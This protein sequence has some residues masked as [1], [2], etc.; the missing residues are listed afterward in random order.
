MTKKEFIDRYGK[1]AYQRRLEYQKQ[2]YHQHREERKQYREQH[3]EERKQYQKQY[4]HQ[5]REEYKQY[6]KQYRE[7]HREERK[8]YQ[9][10]YRE[11]HREQHREEKKQWCR[12]HISMFAYCIPEQIEQ[13]ENYQF[14]KK[15]N[16]DGWNIHHRLE[17]HTSD[18]EK[19]LVNLSKA[20]L[21]ALDMYYNRPANELVFLTKSE[22][23]SL[24]NRRNGLEN[25]LEK[26]YN[27]GVRRKK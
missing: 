20:E 19:R 17:T 4:N 2:H 14:A 9:K 3:R 15:D 16:F 8:Q 22:H 13:I 25:F 11:Q 12:K 7:Q 24:H 1:E 26:D 27:L 6:Q 21:I 23:T 5:Y 10:Q 18:G